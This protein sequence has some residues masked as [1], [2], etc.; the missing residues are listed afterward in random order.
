MY[1]NTSTRKQV[2][3]VLQPEYMALLR[4]SPLLSRWDKRLPYLATGTA[5]G[6]MGGSGSGRGRRM[7]CGLRDGLLRG[8]RYMVRMESV[9]RS[10][11][12][13][14]ARDAGA[15]ANNLDGMWDGS[16]GVELG[17]VTWS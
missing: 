11:W 10:T 9:G 5:G 2:K 14:R 6:G 7:S 3:Q 13:V 12:C 16:A 17:G 1:G 8:K 4:L 15:V